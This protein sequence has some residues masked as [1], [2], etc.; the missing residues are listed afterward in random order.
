MVETFPSLWGLNKNPLSKTQSKVKQ[1]DPNVQL[2]FQMGDDDNLEKL[3]EFVPPDYSAMTTMLNQHLQGKMASLEIKEEDASMAED[4][5]EDSARQLGQ[6]N[7]KEFIDI[8][9]EF[10]NKLKINDLL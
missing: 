6:P 5:D 2:A 7:A 4:E 10:I 3:L 8:I 9:K 1:E